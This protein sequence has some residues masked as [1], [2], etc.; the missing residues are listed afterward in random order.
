MSNEKEIL[1]RLVHHE[2]WEVRFEVARQEYG[3]DV[4]VND[5]DWRVRYEVAKQGYG[6]NKLIN[7]KSALVA[8][9]AARK[10]QE[11]KLK[12]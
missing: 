9:M 8:D 6:L 1:D 7:D 4:L 3:L 11:L 12:E 2:N 10:I 5:E